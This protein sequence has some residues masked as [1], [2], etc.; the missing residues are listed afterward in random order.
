[1][2]ERWKGLSRREDLRGVHDLLGSFRWFDAFCIDQGDDFERNHQ[3]GL[4]RRIYSAAS[5]VFVY[6]GE[7]SSLSNEG[8][9]RLMWAK[10]DQPIDEKGR[11]SLSD[12]FDMRYFSR[13]WVIQEVAN[14]KLATINSGSK[15]MG[16]SILKEQRLKTLDILDN[17]PK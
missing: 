15:T 10:K 13:I 5:E 14:A 17:T 1:M 2:G 8:F 6:L 3:V 12:L 16:W 7:L 9:E 11:R 4:M